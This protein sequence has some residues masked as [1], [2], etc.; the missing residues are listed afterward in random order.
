MPQTLTLLILKAIAAL[1]KYRLKIQIAAAP[2][3]AAGE[4]AEDKPQSH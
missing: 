4:E 1:K 2:E 3:L